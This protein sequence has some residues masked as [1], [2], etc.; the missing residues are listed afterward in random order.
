MPSGLRS[1]GVVTAGVD[2]AC[3]SVALMPVSAST[4]MLQEGR[5]V[6]HSFTLCGSRMLSL[7]LWAP[8][9]R[10]GY[11]PSR[12]ILNVLRFVENRL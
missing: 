4:V 1:A 11:S 5:P 7:G 10:L 6:L 12:L 3:F 9:P 2:V 8:F